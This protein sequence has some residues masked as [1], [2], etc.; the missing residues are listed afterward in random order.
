MR[1]GQGRVETSVPDIPCF[2]GP[3]RALVHDRLEGFPQL[4]VRP[5]SV[6]PLLEQPQGTVSI[7]MTTGLIGPLQQRWDSVT[8]HH[9]AVLVPEVALVPLPL[10]LVDQEGFKAFLQALVDIPKLLQVLRLL[11]SIQ[12][13]CHGHVQVQVYVHTAERLLSQRFRPGTNQGVEVVAADVVGTLVLHSLDMV[14]RQ[15]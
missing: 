8:R 7:H 3:A 15:P 13:A 4:V 11:E 6:E 5:R 9:D 1:D 14:Y 12:G 10:V 2:T